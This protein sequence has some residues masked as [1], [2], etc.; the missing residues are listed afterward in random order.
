S[1]MNTSLII[2]ASVLALS[3]A[4]MTFSDGWEKRALGHPYAHRYVLRRVT[5]SGGARSPQAVRDAGAAAGATGAD[6]TTNTPITPITD[7]QQEYMSGIRELHMAMIDLYSR[8]QTCE[9]AQT[10]PLLPETHQ[11]TSARF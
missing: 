4:Q 1:V 8:Y 11:K 9:N 3:A 10:N 5:R 7:C 2:L 6:E